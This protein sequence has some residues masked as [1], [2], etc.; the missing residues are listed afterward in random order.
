MVFERH[1]LIF[2]DKDCDFPETKD[3]EL[4]W[5]R[6]FRRAVWKSAQQVWG[7][8][9]WLRQHPDRVFL[10]R[11]C[12][13]RFPLRVPSGED[14]VFHRIVV[15]HDTS[16]RRRRAMGGSGSL[17]VNPA[18]IGEQ[19]YTPSS[20]GGHPFAVGQLDP[21]KGYVHVLDEVSLDIVLRYLDSVTDFVS[22]LDKKERAVT[23]GALHGAFGEEDLLA[24]YLKDVN[25]SGEHDFVIPK[26]MHKLFL[27]EGHWRDFVARPE[28]QR[29]FAADRE[30]Y[31]WDLLIEE[32]A[33]NAIAGTLYTASDSSIASQERLLRVLARE[34][35]VRRR[36]LGRSLLEKVL[37]APTPGSFKSRSMLPSFPGDPHYVFVIGSPPP[38]LRRIG[39]DSDEWRTKR[40]H[41]LGAYALA[42]MH[43][44]ADAQR[45]VGI[46][47][48]GGVGE[49]RSHDLVL[50]E[51]A[52]MDEDMHREARRIYAETGWFRKIAVS[53]GTESEYVDDRPRPGD[54]FHHETTKIGRNEPCPCG[55]GKK[56]K[57]C[58][59]AA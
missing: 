44:F 18:I 47:T 36:M 56:F 13:E 41:V 10:D 11:R 42:A 4:A 35:R 7:A 28:V 49:G 22:Y 2:S 40:R 5:R 43:H 59:G 38:E 20:D 39:G 34:P 23:S 50:V 33:Q 51:R 25:S 32:V 37:D 26:G 16:G 3:V 21:N 55:S 54:S 24:Y 52:R 58:H 30:S 27:A 19:H 29:K 53:R 1:V 9:R 17:M 31:L 14:A 48:D 6:W 57:K 8:E 15:A 45:V 12:T 46:A